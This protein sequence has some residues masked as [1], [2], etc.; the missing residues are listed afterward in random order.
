MPPLPPK[1]KSKRISTDPYFAL[2]RFVEKG[3]KN[4]IQV[5]ESYIVLVYWMRG[6]WIIKDKCPCPCDFQTRSYKHSSIDDL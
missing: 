2:K 3:Y 1:M 6:K 5:E 4:N